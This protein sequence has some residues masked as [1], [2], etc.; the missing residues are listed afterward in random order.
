MYSLKMWHVLVTVLVVVAIIGLT[1][2][3]IFVSEPQ[4]QQVSAKGLKHKVS[5]GLEQIYWQWQNEGRPEAIL[6][7]PG[8]ASK[9]VKIP[10][11]ADGRPV[12]SVSQENCL[13]FLNWFIQDDSLTGLVSLGK[14]DKQSRDALGQQS[15]VCRFIIA[16]QGFAYNIQTA[17]V[18]ND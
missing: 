3:H 10:V 14:T 12:F 18:E 5:I 15:A 8:H 2:K 17:Q 16:N 1:V 6:Y 13:E 4:W 9:S 11:N 7:K